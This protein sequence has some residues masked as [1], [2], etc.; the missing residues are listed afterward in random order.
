MTARRLDGLDMALVV[1]Y[2]LGLYLGVSLQVTSKIPLT[3]APSGAA[4]LI[5]LWRRRDRIQP[6]H[7][8]GLLVVL[9]LY[10]GSA[11]VAEDVSFLSKRFT[12]LVQITYSLVIAYAMFLT[13]IEAERDQIAA[14]LL[15]FCL[16]IIVG[17]LLETYGGLRPI[18]DRVREYLY[19]PGVVYDGDRR[20]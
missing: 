11:M 20:D 4:G 12:G 10:L 19:D 17:C 6:A 8:A 7:L 1:L 9:A 16:F 15:V 5:L 13:L 2:L 3:C 18:S 14:I